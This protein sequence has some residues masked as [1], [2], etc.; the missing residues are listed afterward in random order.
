MKY[1]RQFSYQPAIVDAHNDHHRLNEEGPTERYILAKRIEISRRG[2]IETYL[3]GM[4]EEYYGTLCM[5]KMYQDEDSGQW[6]LSTCAT[7]TL[8]APQLQ[9]L[10]EEGTYMVNMSYGSTI[11]FKIMEAQD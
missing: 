5:N 4:P 3:V 9:K 7:F 1:N 2:D 8:D 11:I 6:H 10:H